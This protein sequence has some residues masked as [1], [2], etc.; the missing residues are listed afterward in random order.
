[1]SWVLTVINYIL[2]TILTAN[3]WGKVIVPITLELGTM[4]G[5]NFYIPTVMKHVL[6][7]LLCSNEWYLQQRDMTFVHNGYLWNEKGWA[8]RKVQ[9]CNFLLQH[10]RFCLLFLKYIAFSTCYYSR[11]VKHV[12]ICCQLAHSVY[13]NEFFHPLT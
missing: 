9:S 6:L 3:R 2:T 13:L 11:I 7:D 4:L 8:T 5:K 12:W 1:M 10:L